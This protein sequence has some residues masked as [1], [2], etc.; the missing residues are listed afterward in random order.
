MGKKVCLFIVDPQIDFC[1]PTG[2]LS[3]KGADEDMKRL[4]AM[5]RRTK[6]DLEECVVTLD[7]HRAIH[8]ASPIFW[9]DKD[10]NHPNP[11]T[12]INIDDVAGS[13]PKWRA[14]NLGYQQRSVEYVQKL[15]DN[16]RYQLCIW[17]EHCLIGSVGAAVYPPLFEALGVWEQQFAVVNY[18]TKGSNP[19]TEH[20]SVLKADVFDPEDPGTGLNTSL[21]KLL[22]EMDVVAV[23]G[24]A[25]S[26]CIANSVVDVANNF[27]E[28]NIRKLIYLEDA[29]SPVPG[30][31]HLEKAFLDEMT[32][33]G[34]KV[35]TTEKFLR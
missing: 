34:M 31:E 30:Y 2:K 22:Q 27:G 33:R 7:S 10:G 26:H 28:D 35:S 15:K 14:T 12:L 20:Y 23:G 6:R 5:I 17:P 8:I 29:C 21:I 32:K 4:A 3:V 19:F 25:S 13:N 24:E 16:N 9:K 18:V 11:F 1:D